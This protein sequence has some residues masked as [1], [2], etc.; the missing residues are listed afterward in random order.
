MSEDRKEIDWLPVP[1]W[2]VSQDGYTGGWTA[3]PWRY[4]KDAIQVGRI[5][6]LNAV[7]P[8]TGF[9]F[10]KPVSL[11]ILTKFLR[12]L[13]DVPH[14]S[15]VGHPATASVLAKALGIDVPAN[16]GEYV[17]RAGDLAVVARLKSRPPIGADVEVR[18]EDLQFLLVW[19]LEG[20]Q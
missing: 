18:E 6:F 2:E 5:V 10:M 12:E 13:G 7:I 19:Y 15:F 1:S 4:Y 9:V 17:P 14:E 16:R 8:G 20:A 3:R 11:E